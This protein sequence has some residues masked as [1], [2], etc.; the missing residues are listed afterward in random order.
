MAVDSNMKSII[1][2]PLTLLFSILY[3]KCN[4]VNAYVVNMVEKTLMKPVKE[5]WMKA[6]KNIFLLLLVHSIKEAV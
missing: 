4:Y 2:R 6:K 3:L 5:G 1:G